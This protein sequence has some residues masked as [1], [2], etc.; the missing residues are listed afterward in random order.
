[1]IIAQR[2]SSVAEAD[3]IIVLDDGKIDSIG[4]HNELMQTSEIYQE[5][6]KTQQKGVTE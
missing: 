6:N 5:I 4:T 3:E 1:M 2:I